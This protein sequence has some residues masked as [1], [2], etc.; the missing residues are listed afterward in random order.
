MST[1][2][3]IRLHSP[4][5]KVLNKLR[6]SYQTYVNTY[7]THTMATHHGGT[8]IPLVAANP[9][10]TE[11]DLVPPYDHQEEID[12]KEQDEN[13][14][15]KELTNVVNDIQ[16]QLDATNYEP[17]ETINRIER[18]LCRLTLALCPSAPPEPLYELLQQCT[19][20]LC[21]A[22]QKTTLTSNL[23]QDI[24]IFTDPSQ[25]EDWFTGIESS[26]D[27]THES[28]TKLAQAKSKVWPA[29]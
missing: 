24:T 12:N 29:L 28:H 9:P 23:L 19:E 11:N 1:H 26:A 2:H 25:L 27:L 22:Q 5:K 8:G 6:D 18:E 20:T 3:S 14:Q 4:F 10:H 17:K 21:T 13:T 16:H 7:K 15:L